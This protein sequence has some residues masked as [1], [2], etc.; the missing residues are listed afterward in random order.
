MSLDQLNER[1][2]ETWASGDFPKMGVELAIAGELL[3]EAV[4]SWNRLAFR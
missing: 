4:A 1:Q 2:Q 3:C